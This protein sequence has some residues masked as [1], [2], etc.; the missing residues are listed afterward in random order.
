MKKPIA[1]T[2]CSLLIAVLS[3]CSND[4]SKAKTP[5]T[6][7]NIT[8]N[9][10]SFVYDGTAK[11]IYVDNAPEFATVTYDGNEQINAGKYTV[12]AH[13]SAQDYT[14]LDLSATLTIT[15]ATFTDITF[16]N[17]SFEYDGEP[18]SIYVTGAPSNATVTYTNNN[19]T[20]VGVYTVTARISNSNYNTLTKTATMTI[21]GKTIT[22]I[23]FNDQ[24]YE[25]DG[26][27][28]SLAISGELP[29]GVTVSYSGNGKTDSGTYTVTATLSGEGYETLVLKAKLTITPFPVKNPGYL[30]DACFV[31]DGQNHSIEVTSVPYGATVTYKCTN[32]TGTNT[33][34]EPG[35]YKIEATVS[36]NKN[37]ASTLKATMIIV[38]NATIGVDPNKTALTID[39]NLTW[40]DLYNALSGWN[41]TYDYYDG[42]YDVENLD[43]PR[44]SDLFTEDCKD[45][46]LTSHFVTDGKEAYFKN[47]STY[48]E[49]YYY[50]YDYYKEIGDDMLHLH[51]HED[52]ASTNIEKFPKDA[53]IETVSQPEAANAFI[54]IQ[55]GENGEIEMGVEKEEKPGDVGYPFIEDDKFVVLMEHPRTISTGYRYFYKIY[56]FYNIGNTKLEISSNGMPSTDY[57][58]NECGFMAYRLG[59]VLYRNAGFGTASNIKYYYTA[60]LY[61][62]Y[63][64]KVFLK[65]GTYTVLPYIYNHPV[66]AIVHYSY[67]GQYYNYDQSGYTF[68][69][70]IDEELNYQGEYSDLGTLSKLDIK[71]VVNHGGLVNY[72]SDWHQ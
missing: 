40:D 33:F 24:T 21:T 16:E 37:Q 32:A 18:H 71:D 20:S 42:C 8:F 39:E 27:S 55:R 57:V 49:P 64:I 58:Q 47:H 11:S 23:T 15:K 9:S 60:Q 50:S 2:L 61:V 46:Q 45:H 54:A 63:R 59:G 4:S 28:H 35:I 6:F 53:F 65:P 25:Y 22:G 30:F 69:L 36:I 48:S 5:N 31:Y 67:Y 29:T 52:G 72:Y 7:T 19:K 68:N 13:V 44:P 17:Q 70:Y 1:L 26:K 14:T 66:M 34:K 38:E 12:T 41:F 10:A 43:D 3:G 56:K 51:F 62:S